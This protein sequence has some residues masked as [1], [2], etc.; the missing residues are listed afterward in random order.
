[1]S[2]T[3]RLGEKTILQEAHM[4]TSSYLFTPNTCDLQFRRRPYIV[5][6][7]STTPHLAKIFRV[8]HCQEE[9]FH[10][11]KIFHIA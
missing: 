9:K 10:A 5:R 8:Y 7:E 4:I 3:P 6:A 2:I 11:E 1:L